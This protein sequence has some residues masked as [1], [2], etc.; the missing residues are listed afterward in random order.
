MNKNV[1][2]HPFSL[3]RMR[4]LAKQA[5]AISRLYHKIRKINPDLIHFQ[6]GYLW[7]NPVLF[8]L[9]RYPIV[10]TI[11]DPRMHLGDKSSKKTPQIIIDY[12]FSRATRVIVHSE[13]MKRIVIEK[14]RILNNRIDITHMVKQGDDS[15]KSDV[16]EEKNL[17]LFF[18]RIWEYKGL[19]YLIK[20]EPL[21]TAE[22]PNARIIIAGK[23]ENIDDYKKN[24]VNPQNFIIYNEYVSDKKRAELFRKAS[25]VVLPYV[26]A[27]QSGVIPVAY[28]YKKAVVATRV[29]G[30]PEQI[31][32]GHT[33]FIVPPKDEKA[34]AKAIVKLLKDK[35]MRKKFGENG[36]KKLKI[37]SSPINVA[38]ETIRVY[39]RAYAD[40]N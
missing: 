13:Q 30:I 10:V 12:G 21:I 24:M 29:G 3:P 36:G 22:V 5:V 19:K 20:A 35:K 9:K 23:G 1:N 40:K 6:Q 11:H 16:A 8:F 33:G 31:D 26:D 34:L 17:V 37:E 18:G 32:N 28:S 2:F 7:F 14:C 27:S 38:Q 25:I 15:I 4:Q 39:E